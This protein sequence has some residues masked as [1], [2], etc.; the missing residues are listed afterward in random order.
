M[1]KGSRVGIR[2]NALATQTLNYTLDVIGDAAKTIGGSTWTVPSDIRWK[3]D[4]KDLDGALDLITKLRGV[5]FRWKEPEQHGGV[6]TPQMGLIAQEVEPV[7]PE[8]VTTDAEGYKH[9]TAVGFEGLFIEAIKELKTD[10]ETAVNELKAENVAL[11][12]R[13]EHL[14]Q[15]LPEDEVAP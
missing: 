11:R 7:I 9:L 14:E 10:H 12:A 15:R 1:V 4:I 2:Q 5:T 6:M 8:W 13:L 3:E